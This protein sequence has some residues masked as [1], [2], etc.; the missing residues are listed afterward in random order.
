MAIEQRTKVD[1]VTFSIITSAYINLVDEM[2]NTVKRSCM[3]LAIFVGDFSG[4]MMN[5]DGELVAMGTRDISVHVGAIQPST[6]ACIEDFGKEKIYPGDVFVFNDP[7]RGGTHLPDMTFIRPVFWDGELVAFTAT[8]GHWSDVGG[9]TPG[10]MNAMA[11]EIYK[12]GLLVPPM[13]IYER[14]ELRHD[15]EKLILSNLRLEEECGGDMRAQVEATKTGEARLHQLI[16]KYGIETILGSFEENLDLTERELIAELQ[17]YPEGTWEGEDFV[18]YDPKYPERGPVRVHVKMT[19]THNPTHIVYDV[20]GSG[21]ATHSGMNGTLASSFGGLVAATKYVFPKPLLNAGWL[22]VIS[23]EYP[24]SSVLNAVRPQACCGEV[25]G[26]YEKVLHAVVRIWSQLRPERVFAACF[27]LEYFMGGGYDDRPDQD[28]RY[29]MY[30]H[31]HNGGWGARYGLDGRD[32]G[33]PL[34]GCG[35]QQQSIEHME[36]IWPIFLEKYSSKRDSM[37]AGK[38]RG[39]VGTESRLTVENSS[40]TI[41][42][43]VCDRG[44]YGP[45]GPPGLFGGK[46]GIHQGVTKNLGKDN[47]EYLDV[48]FSNVSVGQGESMY[49]YS[50]GGGG[51][52]NP[53]ERD[54]RAVLEDVI[55]DFVSIEAARNEYGVVI[56]AVDPDILDFRIDE[57]ATAA[58]RLE[59]SQNGSADHD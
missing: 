58:V 1:P 45:G 10:S 8:K 47:E 6:Q 20:R 37:G 24:E 23:A 50:A 9:S 18:D 48:Y 3:S 4:G 44:K 11:D 49:H 41:M 59:M 30:Y 2:V 36:R 51:Y 33:A 17:Q 52:G 26:A 25:S 55:D 40:G 32:G 56:E 16:G 5:A 46:R 34:F 53:L 43:Y 57:K 27:N 39:G 22:R 35:L 31:W 12:E 54:P 29:F 14:G 42:S 19:L 15:V 28:N 21:P 13:K 7:Y 38:W